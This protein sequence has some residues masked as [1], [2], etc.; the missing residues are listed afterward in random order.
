[1]DR[2]QVILV[3]KMKTTVL[4]NT[5]MIQYCTSFACNTPDTL[6]CIRMEKVVVVEIS[7][8]D[9]FFRGC[10]AIISWYPYV[11]CSVYR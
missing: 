2:F 1:M 4:Y 11:L 10:S 9:A 7:S 8:D 5:S 6:L 3:L